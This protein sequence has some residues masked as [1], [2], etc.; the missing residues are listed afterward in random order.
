[1][2]IFILHKINKFVGLGIILLCF[3]CNSQNENKSVVKFE[4]AVTKPV[5]NEPI[6]DEILGMEQP[7][8]GKKRAKAII[9]RHAKGIT[10][11]VCEADTAKKLFQDTLYQVGLEMT[12]DRIIEGYSFKDAQTKRLIPNFNFIST[13]NAAYGEHHPVTLSPD[14]IWLLICQGV[15][16]HINEN[17]EAMRSQFVNHQ[18]QAVISIIRPDFVKNGYNDWANTLPEF[19]AQVK[20]YLKD[21]ITTWMIPQFSTT[22]ANATVAYQ[23]T[24]LE[25]MQKYFLNRVGG[26]GIPFITLEGATADWKKIRNLAENLRKYQ[27][28]DWVE[29]LIPVL[30]QF[31]L[32]SEGK[33]EVDFWDD[34]IKYALN[35]DDIAVNGWITKFFPYIEDRYD[36][37]KF[38]PNPYLKDKD[39]QKSK[40]DVRDFPDCV[41]KID[42]IWEDRNNYR[43]QME[44]KAGFI[45]ATQDKTTKSL[46]PEIA[47]AVHDKQSPSPQTRI[48]Y[49]TN[50]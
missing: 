47:W 33:V 50:K 11:S 21:D 6:E 24:L 7:K 29:A 39:Y 32:A 2:K 19:T 27:L 44:F 40:L 45:G 20:T 3:A 5:K 16:N 36:K 18:G 23:V 4:K 17:A 48:E 41:S 10:F 15:S 1:M 30:D 26:C 46:R 13:L 35:Y 31:V 43:S 42:I 9:K 38:F 14:M 28:N 8:R 25:S 37:G 49:T 12:L 22:D 34:M